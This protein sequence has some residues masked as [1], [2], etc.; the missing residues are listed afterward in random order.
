MRVFSG[1]PAGDAVV[2]VL[3]S[4][5]ADI[6]DASLISLSKAPSLTLGILDPAFGPKTS[7]EDVAESPL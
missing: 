7:A 6:T 1:W 3:P 2:A 4:V 5:N